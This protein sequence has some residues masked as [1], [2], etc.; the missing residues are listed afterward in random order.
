MFGDWERRSSDPTDPAPWHTYHITYCALREPRF[1]WFC[2]KA[3]ALPIRSLS[4]RAQR[5][6]VSYTF[7]FFCPSLPGVSFACYC[8]T[9]ARIGETRDCCGRKLKTVFKVKFPRFRDLGF[10]RHKCVGESF[11]YSDECLSL[12]MCP[13]LQEIEDQTAG[14]DESFTK[15]FEKAS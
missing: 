4:L 3:T 7:T 13:S 14:Q 2:T 9:K 6:G 1:F 8:L 15:L 5:Q 10:M 11:M 12:S